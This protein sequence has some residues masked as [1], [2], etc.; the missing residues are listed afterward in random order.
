M[1]PPPWE[2]S[3]RPRPLLAAPALLPALLQSAGYQ[4][5]AFGKSAP[6][7]D[8][9]RS[10]L[11]WGLPGL[12]GF[13]DYLGQPN[14]GYCHNMYPLSV[15]AGN[16]SLKLPLNEKNKSRAACMADPSAY[17]YTT[18][19]FTEAALRWLRGRAMDPLLPFLPECDEDEREVA[20]AGQGAHVD[21][22]D[23]ERHGQGEADR[24]RNGVA[25]IEHG[26]LFGGATENEDV[27]P[28]VHD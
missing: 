15:T 18:D 22:D 16:Q 27:V 17:N 14:Q 19:I 2:A 28:P 4:T 7:D 20:L 23:D 5:A 13:E 1:A 6:M 8:T 10:T 12:H 11:A 21:A 9:A 24:N 26:G 25:E 3:A